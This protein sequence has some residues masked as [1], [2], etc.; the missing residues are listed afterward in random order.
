M[1]EKRIFVIELIIDDTSNPTTLNIDFNATKQEIADFINKELPS[2]DNRI[3]SKVIEKILLEKEIQMKT[4]KDKKE[5]VV[6]RLYNKDKALSKS[7]TP[8]KLKEKEKND[9]NGNNEETQSSDFSSSSNKEQLDTLYAYN[10][11][12]NNAYKYKT[13]NNK[14][15][16]KSYDYEEYKK[17]K[18]KIVKHL[19]TNNISKNK[20]YDNIMDKDYRFRSN[21]PNPYSPRYFSSLVSSSNYT[22]TR[23]NDK[24]FPFY[25]KMNINNTIS[26]L[27]KGAL[28]QVVQNRNL[29][30][31]D[32]QISNYKI[33]KEVNRFKE[34]Q[35]D[36]LDK[37]EEYEDNSNRNFDDDNIFISK[38]N[39]NIS[40]YYN[41]DKNI[42]NRNAGSKTSMNERIKYFNKRFSN[43]KSK[44]GEFRR[45]NNE[46]KNT[47]NTN[48]KRLT[49]NKINNNLIVTSN[50]NVNINN[51][52][53]FNYNIL[54]ENNSKDSNNK[55]NSFDNLSSYKNLTNINVNSTNKV[56]SHQLSIDNKNELNKNLNSTSVTQSNNGI[57]LKNKTNVTS[58][59]NELNS[60]NTN[61]LLRTYSINNKDNRITSN[62]NAAKSNS[63]I[64]NQLMN[65]YN[66]VMKEYEIS[67]KKSM[68]MMNKAS[69]NN[70]S[71]FKIKN[72]PTSIKNIDN[73]NIE[74]VYN[75]YSTSNTN[76]VKMNS[77]NMNSS[78]RLYNQ[79]TMS[80]KGKEIN[81]R[82]VLSSVSNPTNENIDNL[83]SNC[84]DKT[85]NDIQLDINNVNNLN[86]NSR[87]NLFRKQN[88]ILKT[89][90][91]S[92]EKVIIS[93]KINN[94]NNNNSMS[95]LI[96]R[97]QSEIGSKN[98]KGMNSITNYNNVNNN[99]TTN[100]NNNTNN[101]SS[102]YTNTEQNNNIG[103]FNVNSNNPP[104]NKFKINSK[105][106]R[107]LNKEHK[108]I[109]TFFENT[110]K[111]QNFL[112]TT[113]K[114]K[115]SSSLKSHFSKIAQEVFDVITDKCND[116]SDIL[117]LGEDLVSKDLKQNILIPLL[118]NLHQ[119]NLE[120]NYDNF[121]NEFINIVVSTVNL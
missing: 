19:F 108:N 90:N 36:F 82:G 54:N 27:N 41:N 71:N 49:K 58:S 115:I 17:L 50:E 24:M 109:Q 13:N 79:H 95:R 70:T 55:D 81:N 10:N 62:R 83:E 87:L 107:I 80:S 72:L 38:T 114:T 117:S 53:V 37:L 15:K 74:N 96:S 21:T 68:K 118:V 46:S 88:E 25:K 110:N 14:L 30:T 94:K 111:R 3:T 31:T 16:F 86:A 8:N 47:Y 75:A 85:N 11:Y 66:S 22:S 76:L 64:N 39:K 5:G 6:S 97:P 106:E 45:K 113:A 52:G 61:E 48:N 4:L 23:I 91:K 40:L 35:K 63:E 7:V 121:N 112:K 57:L 89:V 43:I 99:K 78:K 119:Q 84:D 42:N 59:K 32:K 103:N 65:N 69:Y 92:K 44:V 28:D 120:F 98:S 51:D 29:D 9:N 12:Y 34:I 73:F 102:S 101:N 77:N 26:D 93:K 1:P 67:N 116:F 104:Y 60:N 105:T 2:L 56:F 100:T 20:E 33:K 18:P